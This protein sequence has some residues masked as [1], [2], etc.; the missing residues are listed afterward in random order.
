MANELDLYDTDKLREARN[1]IYKV[2]EYNF[3][4]RYDPLS[5]KLETILKKIDNL[6]DKSAY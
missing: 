4:S 5:K 3:K 2:Y 6:I 1:I